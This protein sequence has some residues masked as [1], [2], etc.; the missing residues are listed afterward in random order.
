VQQN[1]NSII[2]PAAVF[3]IVAIL[4]SVVQTVPE[5]PLLLAERLFCNGGWLQV[6]LISAY[7]AFLSFKMQFRESR[8]IWRMRSW[9]LFTVI[10][11]FQMILGVVADSVFLFSGKLHVPVP[12]ILI[13]GPMYRFSSWFMII[14]FLSAILVAGPAWCSHLCYFGSMDAA[15]SGKIKKKNTALNHL[16]R[17][18]VL[19]LVVAVALILRLVSGS[20]NFATL[21]AI[22]FGVLGIGIILFVSRKRG[23]MF[24]CINYCPV[25]TVVSRLKYISPFRFR[26][27]E[28]CTKCYACTKSCKYQALMQENIDKGKIGS[29]CTYCGDC[30][31]T[32]KHGALEYRFMNL[33]PESSE[34]LWII[35]TVALHSIFLAV[36]RV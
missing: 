8:A 20:G 15:A 24:H 34:R 30:L 19:I 16:L 25:G 11:Y 23:Y 6:F 1:K 14:L 13:A 26:L 3:V 17:F 36:A 21:L 12:A 18:S 7:S 27:K 33:S 9:T 29:T 10:F 22:L 32:C 4:L 35:I 31:V 28:N 2:I 5:K